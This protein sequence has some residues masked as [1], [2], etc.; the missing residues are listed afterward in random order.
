MWH[1]QR[2]F[3]VADVANYQELLDK[4]KGEV[5]TWCLCNGF[6][7]Q[8]YLW[9]NDSLSENGAQEYAVVREADLTQVESV[10]V[11]WMSRA[12]L[13]EFMRLFVS[14]GLVLELGVVTNRIDTVEEH[15]KARC[16]LC[17]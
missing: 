12:E 11:S 8:G 13:A 16:P 10:T 4:F 14:D 6:R 5:G 17:A 3:V 9:L 15:R 7:C 1:K 2:R